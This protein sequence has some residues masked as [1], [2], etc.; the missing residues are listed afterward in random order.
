MKKTL[1]I[2]MP[3]GKWMVDVFSQAN[4]SGEFD[5]VHPNTSAEIS[6]NEGE[7]YGFRYSISGKQG[8]KFTIEL[9]DIVLVEGEIDKSETAKGSGVI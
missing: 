4:D 8:T 9:D 2:T 1:K 7:M 6:F 3:E 5:L